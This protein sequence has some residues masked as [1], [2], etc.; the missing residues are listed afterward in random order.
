MADV[1]Q[2]ILALLATLQTGRAFTADELVARLGVSPR[3]LRRDVDRLREYGYPVR[4]RPGPGGHYRLVAG[5]ALPP[6]VLDDDEAIA[7]L[8]GLA[9]L[10][11][12]GRAAEG[13]VDEAAT[14][15]YGKVD[16]FLPKRLRHRAAQLRASLETS[17]AAA[18]SVSADVLAELAEAIQRRLVV[19]FDYTGRDGAVTSRRAE[20]Y[21]HV[22]HNL[23][24]YLL[25][26]DTA[27]D[28]WRVFRLDRLTGLRTSTS[29]YEPRPLP[30][31][32]ALDYLRQG[33]GK[34]R[35]RVVLTVEAPLA[36][37]ADAFAYED[38]DLE[39]LGERRT[40]AVLALDTWEWLLLRLAFLD[41]PFTV[42]E[43]PGFRAALRSFGARLTG[44]GGPA[45]PVA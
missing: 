17:A 7:T 3:T 10:A 40:R 8:L 23:R 20:P 1:T 34:D 24:W 29:T 4:T 35:E 31:D 16:Q 25:A 2:R 15:A 26:R 22:H 12:T 9:T 45:Q 30:A 21:R 33:L 43:P 18:P 13:S 42:E 28:D 27:K 36:D 14:R 39:A 44:G 19:T 38:A 11:A 37:V 32:T 6:L 5:S 41:A